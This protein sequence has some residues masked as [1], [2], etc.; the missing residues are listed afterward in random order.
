MNRTFETIERM[1]FAVLL[2]RERF[3]VVV[4]AQITFRH[5]S[6]LFECSSAN[7]ALPSL[8]RRSHFDIDSV[9][10]KMR[11]RAPR[12]TIL[13]G[14]AAASQAERCGWNKDVRRESRK[15]AA[16]DSRATREQ[17]NRINSL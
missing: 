13:R 17:T 14:I 15:S 1:F 5:F 6:F 11:P 7:A 3:V 9:E 8:T 10:I 16:R 4:P 12:S 2:N